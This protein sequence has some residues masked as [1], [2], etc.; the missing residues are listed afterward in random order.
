MVI[1]KTIHMYIK[2]HDLFNMSR[3]RNI[4]YFGE[5]NRMDALQC[6]LFVEYDCYVIRFGRNLFEFDRVLTIWQR[7]MRRM[8][9]SKEENCGIEGGFNWIG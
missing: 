5:R 8:A 1:D 4:L 7:R 3:K 6:I 9:T 2:S